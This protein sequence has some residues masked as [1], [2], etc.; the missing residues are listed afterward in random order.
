MITYENQ[1]V[2]CGM[3]CLGYMCPFRRVPVFACDLCGSE[4]VRLWICGGKEL[5]EA[6]AAAC[7]C[8][9]AETV[10]LADLWE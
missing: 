7:G 5:C 2:G 4:E 6:C 3:P 9:D 1:C 8:E 10:D